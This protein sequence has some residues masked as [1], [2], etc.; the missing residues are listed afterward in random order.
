VSWYFGVFEGFKGAVCLSL[1][2]KGKK[3]SDIELQKDEKIKCQWF[4]Y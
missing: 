2:D 4:T 3:L 1:Q